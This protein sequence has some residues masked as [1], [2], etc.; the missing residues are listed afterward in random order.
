MQINRKAGLASNYDCGQCSCPYNYTPSLNYL[1]PQSQDIPVEGTGGF[2]FYAG[3][4]DC[5]NND[6]YYNYATS[7]SWRLWKLQHRLEPGI[8]V[9]QR[10]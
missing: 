6:Y 7:A 10:C 4:A 3:Y 8:W 1:T 5:N 2:L 9:I